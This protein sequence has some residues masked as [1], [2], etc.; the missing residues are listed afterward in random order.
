[1]NEELPR[2]PALP[3]PLRPPL[4]ETRSRPRSSSGGSGP[5]FLSL[6]Y[7]TAGAAD[8][9]RPFAFHEGDRVVLRIPNCIEFVVCALALHRL[10]AVVVPTNVLLR[11][12]IVTHIANTS[13]AKALIAHRDF[14][15]DV[16]A[17]RGRLCWAVYRPGPQ[18]WPSGVPFSLT[19]AVEMAERLGAPATPENTWFHPPLDQPPM[20][21]QAARQL[22]R[23]DAVAGMFCQHGPGEPSLDPVAFRGILSPVVVLAGEQQAAL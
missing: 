13:E 23:V 1:M 10:G 14:V 11:E 9:P 21:L 16:E 19:S 15:G 12:R 22:G 4:R 7:E 5:P 6:E 17:G 8:E 20:L 3:A 18:G 2:R